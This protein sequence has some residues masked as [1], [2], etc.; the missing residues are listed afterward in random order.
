MARGQRERLTQ[1]LGGIQACAGPVTAGTTPERAT[2]APSSQGYAESI[3]N[4][5]LIHFFKIKNAI[6]LDLGQK[7]AERILALIRFCLRGTQVVLRGLPSGSRP[8]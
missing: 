4:E 7:Q 3:L 5:V 1:P 6:E 2:R 8:D